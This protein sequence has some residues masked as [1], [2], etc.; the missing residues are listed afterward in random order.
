MH[1]F[2][3]PVNKRGFLAPIITDVVIFQQVAIRI[4]VSCRGRDSCAYVSSYKSN[5]VDHSNE[6]IQDLT[7]RSTH[8]RGHNELSKP[9]PPL[10]SSLP[11]PGQSCHRQ[12]ARALEQWIR[13]VNTS[14]ES[15]KRR[16]EL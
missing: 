8:S 10:A 2:Q 11:T 15:S 1:Y 7:R 6:N 16:I 13:I 3:V 5:T 9:T 14:L 4:S 12:H